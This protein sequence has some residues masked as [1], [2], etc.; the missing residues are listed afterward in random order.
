[1]RRRQEEEVEGQHADE[2]DSE[3]PAEAPDRRYRKHREE[4]DH[5]ETQHGRD[6]TQ[7]ID[8][9][10]HDGDRHEAEECRSELHRTFFK[11]TPRKFDSAFGGLRT[12]RDSF[13]V[14]CSQRGRS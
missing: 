2:G 4:V 8:S 13:A 9:P 10:G 11:G 3:R 5:P 1:M 7:G 14:I 12:S 6:R